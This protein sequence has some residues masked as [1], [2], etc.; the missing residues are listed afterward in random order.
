MSALVAQN[1]AIGVTGGIAAYKTCTLVRELKKLGAD[2]R[3]AISES[4]REFVTDLTFATLSENPVVTSLFSGNET[5]GTTHIEM[6]RW[7][8]IFVVCPA[9]AH[10]LARAAVGMAND[11]ITTTLLATRAKVLICPAMNSVMWEKQVVQENIKKLQQLGYEIVEP[12]W[13]ALATSDE[14]EGWGRLPEIQNI[15]SRIQHCLLATDDFKGQ[16]VIVSAGPTREAI[17]PVRFLT[18]YSTGKMGFALAEVA[19]QRGAEVVL[20][21]GPN[22]LDKP[23][24]VKYLEIESAAELQAVI[25][26][27][28]DDCDILLM[29]AAVSDYR[30]RVVL[31]H[32]LKKKAGEF[33]LQMVRNADILA[34][35]GKKKTAEVHVGFALETESGIANATK[36]LSA[37]NLDFIVL[38]NPL[39]PGAAFAGDTNVVTIISK[40]GLVDT[41]PKMSKK[42]VAHTVLDRVLHVLEAGSQPL[43]AG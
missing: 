10:F 4:T 5:S 14:G 37:K 32:K 30:P 27:E 2:V 43:A 31:K 6:A 20:I 15:V 16:K 26:N 8:N 34:E 17:D 3:V 38:N 24:G 13:G 41:L 21:T 29:T 35:L 1:V 9:T 39:E 18:N 19:R 22:H 40:D 23:N 11:F 7:C 36:K 28:Y 25:T 42:E 33:Q 12:E